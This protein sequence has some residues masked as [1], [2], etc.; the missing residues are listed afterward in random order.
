M[1]RFF[2]FLKVERFIIAVEYVSLGE[3]L[4]AICRE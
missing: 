1:C 3:V 4:E 2:D